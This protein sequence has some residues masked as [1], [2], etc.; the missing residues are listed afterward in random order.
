MARCCENRERAFTLALPK[1][2]KANSQRLPR[3]NRNCWL[4]TVP[5]QGSSKKRWACGAKRVCGRWN[6]RHWSKPPSS[7]LALS[8]RL[9]TLPPSPA[10]RREHIKLQV[11]LITPL[12]HLKGYAAP[13][14][15]TAAERARQLIEQAEALREPPEDPLLLF[16]VLYGFWTASYVAFD[17]RAVRELAEQFLALAEKLGTVAPLMIGHRLMGISLLHTGDI[18]E[19]RLHLDHAIALYDPAEHRPLATRFG[20]DARV[21]VLTYRSWALWLLGYPEAA[22]ADIDHALQEAREIGQVGTLLYALGLT[23]LS[24]FFR[25]NYVAVTANSDELIALADVKGYSLFWKARGMMN[26]GCVLALTGR[27]L[28]AVQMI[29]A[30]ITARRSNRS[31]T[32]CAVFCI[33]FGKSICG[34]WQIR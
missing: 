4:V 8:T 27:D 34:S 18:A 12:I 31:N 3:T 33:V 20:V 28:D 21:S 17:G 22:L 2:W 5:R 26:R 9:R 24:Y 32:E 11:A 1:P 29:T 30:G 23:S 13:E 16:S 14:T 10:L 25:R 7:L 6:G 15:K 19:A